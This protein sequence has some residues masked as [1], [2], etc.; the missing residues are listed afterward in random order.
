MIKKRKEKYLKIP[1]TQGQNIEFQLFYSTPIISLIKLF[2][3]Y[4]S[5]EIV[6]YIKEQ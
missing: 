2:P 5:V 6:I 4:S 3:N 1:F